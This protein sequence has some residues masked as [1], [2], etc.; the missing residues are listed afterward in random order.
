MA[1]IKIQKKRKNFSIIDNSIIY[2]SQLSW[3][4]RGLLIFLLSKQEDWEIY[5]THLIKQGP[6]GRDSVY[7]G[8]QEL[9]EAGYIYHERIRN[10]KGQYEKGN[11]IVSEEAEFKNVKEEAK[12]PSPEKPDVAKDNLSPQ[13]E[14][15]EEENPEEGNPDLGNQQLLN[16][17]TNNTDINKNKTTAKVNSAADYIINKELTKNQ[18]AQVM[19]LVE[20]Y[21]KKLGIN[22]EELYQYI[23]YEILDKNTYTKA[24]N[25]FKKKLNTIQKMIKESKWSPPVRLSEHKKLSKKRDLADLKNYIN[26]ISTNINNLSSLLEFEIENGNEE[27]SRSLEEQLKNLKLNLN[28]TKEEYRSKYAEIS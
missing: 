24:D 21:N 10:N 17:N 23:E 15:P 2:N 18:Q 26:A 20:S 6:D 4:A 25:D 19:E 7:S 5:V 11:Y 27:R 22:S 14:N 13:T 12:E 9:I 1:V 3:K 8:I 16:T 28:Q